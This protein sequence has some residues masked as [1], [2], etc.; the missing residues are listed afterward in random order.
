M[1]IIFN[2]KILALCLVVLMT[3]SLAACGKKD[4]KTEGG[5]TQVDKIN[6][7]SE[8][9]EPEVV[10]EPE[11]EEEE[12]S[13]EGKYRSELTNE[14]ID[15]ELKD[16]RPIAAMIDNEKTALN[17]FGTNKADI[18]YEIMNSTANDRIT[19]LMCLFKDYDNIDQIG[20]IRSVRPTNFMVAAEY[21]AI[22]CHD[23]GPFYIDEYIARDYSAHF[24][25][26]FS[27]VSNGKSREFTEYILKGDMDKNFANSKVSK[28]YNEYYDG[29]HFEFNNKF[30]DLDEQGSTK[31]AKHVKLPFYHNSSELKFNEDTNT[32]DYYEYG[33]PHV[34]EG[35]DKKVT[36]FTNV[37]LQNCSFAQLDEN[38]YLVYNVIGDGDGYFLSG[39]KA[40]KIKWAKTSEQGKT[41]FISDETG[42][43]IKLNTGKT[44]IG[45]IPS[46][47]WSEVE[48]N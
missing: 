12:E 2:R 26:T 29:P 41:L 22:I 14:W 4:E 6:L 1:K 9:V 24:S 10:E 47:T 8:Y 18:I 36:T 16:V 37:I 21:N 20:S 42:E 23:G 19:R 33:N 34:D 46:D 38:G 44:Y 35:D 27:R 40:I 25:G 3:V 45:I 13:V 7:T 32:Y 39:G 11:E 15:E 28:E 31:E 43:T 48:L 17:H 5:S 30:K